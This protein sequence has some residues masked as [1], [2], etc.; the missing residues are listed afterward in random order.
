MNSRESLLRSITDF[1]LSEKEAS[2]YLALLELGPST[3][4]KISKFTKI[5]RSTIYN[6]IDSLVKESLA[7]VEVRGFKRLYTAENPD[8]LEA[9]FEKRK[10]S[11]TEKIPL[12]QE[13]YNQDSN[14]SLIK[15]YEGIESIKLLYSELLSDLK[16]DIDY[17]VVGNQEAWL[18]IDPDFFMKFIEKRA[19][20]KINIRLLLQDS[21]T[22]RKYKNFERNFNQ[23]VK[24]LPKQTKLTTNMVILPDKVIIHQ[25]KGPKLAI[26]IKNQNV[27]RMNKELFEIAWSSIA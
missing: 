2:V 23:R 17:L 19:K 25:L 12:M 21:A 27:V 20:L 24:I 6:I 10:A 3:I 16:N 22:T 13:L 14:D 11:L 8:R 7:A 1:G 5:N 15:Y 26:V 4:L 18:S 9:I